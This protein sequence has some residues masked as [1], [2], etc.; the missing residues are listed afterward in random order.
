MAEAKTHPQAVAPEFS[1]LRIPPRRSPGGRILMIDHGSSPTCSIADFLTTQGFQAVKVKGL[2]DL[3]K[4]AR[5]LTPAAVIIDLDLTTLGFDHVVRV[6]R[7]T[8]P[9]VPLLALSNTL[10]RWTAELVR[11][12]N[13]PLL[14]KP[15][16]DTTLLAALDI[17][18]VSCPLD[19]S[20]YAAD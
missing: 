18:G 12:F 1:L 2:T 19:T 13:V 8:H 20:V 9:T 6:L 4:H 14:I 10:E 7:G 17:L 15:C 11:E 3:I 5:I 16:A